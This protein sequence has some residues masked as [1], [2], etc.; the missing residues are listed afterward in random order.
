MDF[1]HIILEK[2]QQDLFIRI[3]EIM[4]QVPREN[5]G[6]MIEANSSDGTCLI[7]PRIDSQQNNI[8][9][10]ARGDL[11]MIAEAELMKGEATKSGGNRY[12]LKPVAYGYYDWLMKQQG[13]PVERVQENIFRYFE[14]EDF[15]KD[16]KEAYNKLKQ[17]EELLWSSDSEANFSAIGHHCREAMQEFADTLYEQVLGKPSDDPKAS[18]VKRIRAVIEVKSA[19]AG[20]TVTAF[21]EALLPFWGTVSNLVQRQ[22]H[23]GQKEGESINWEDARRVVFQTANVM[24]EL[25]RGLR[26]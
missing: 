4:K 14:F 7:M 2:E 3:V 8:T 11:D 6:W 22:E 9:G 26:E 18:T 16:H 17:A 12:V 20:K 15:R 5:R 1:S 23:A 24:F 21:L 10:F 25:N 19:E 13:K